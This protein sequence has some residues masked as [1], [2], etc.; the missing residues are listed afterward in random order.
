MKRT[1]IL[2]LK[3]IIAGTVMTA[4]M[5]LMVILFLTPQP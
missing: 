1:L 3:H 2:I 5:L 4:V